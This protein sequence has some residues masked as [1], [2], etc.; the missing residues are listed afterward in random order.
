MAIVR[1]T[2]TYCVFTCA[3]QPA[4]LNEGLEVQIDS[5][6]GAARGVDARGRRKPSTARAQACVEFRKPDFSAFRITTK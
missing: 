3:S 1:G 6:S 5:E 4:E 2:W